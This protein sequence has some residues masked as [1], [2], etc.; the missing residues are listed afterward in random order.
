MDYEKISP[1]RAVV[2]KYGKDTVG[3]GWIAV[4]FLAGPTPPERH[5]SSRR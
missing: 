4:E 5:E 2:Q 1:W 3:A